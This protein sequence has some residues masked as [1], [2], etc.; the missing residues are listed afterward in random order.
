MRALLLVMIACGAPKQPAVTDDLDMPRRSMQ[1][2]VE[3]PTDALVID[4]GAPDASLPDAAANDGCEND[5]TAKQ[6][7]E[8]MG[9]K[10]APRMVLPCHRGD[11]APVKPV[12]RCMCVDTSKPRNCP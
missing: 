9:V 7:C 10:F 8:S 12:P 6:A 3:E 5:P 4:A 1:E 2:P 11:G